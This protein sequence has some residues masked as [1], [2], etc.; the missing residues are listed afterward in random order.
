[1]GYFSGVN[2]L[3]WSANIDSENPDLR[4]LRLSWVF[5]WPFW[6]V[7]TKMITKIPCVFYVL[8]VLKEPNIWP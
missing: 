3:L 4:H 7:I 6:D 1:M 8:H 5:P 2:G